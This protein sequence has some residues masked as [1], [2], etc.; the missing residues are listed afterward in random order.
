MRTVRR[1]KTKLPVPLPMPTLDGTQAIQKDE[2]MNVA[3]P[4]GDKRTGASRQS[5]EAGTAWHFITLTHPHA[6][7]AQSNR[8]QVRSHAMTHFQRQSR[9]SRSRGHRSLRKDE[10]ELDVRPL[11][12]SHT[13]QGRNPETGLRFTFEEPHNPLDSI[14][15]GRLDPF[16]NSPIRMGTCEN[17][18]YDHR[19]LQDGFTTSVYRFIVF[20]QTCIMFRTMQRIGFL[21]CVRATAAFAQLLAMSSWHLVHLNQCR[22]RHEYLSLSVLAT[23]ELQKQIDV[24]SICCKNE[25]IAAVVLFLC[26]A[27]SIYPVHVYVD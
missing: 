18:L 14:G 11:L 25:T 24:P 22:P 13:T 16:F 20:D 21:T 6:A 23:Q 9:V 5:L 10:V 7:K 12:A 4:E 27:V 3:E 8:R 19:K 26:C 17:E 2:R 1:D 15:Y